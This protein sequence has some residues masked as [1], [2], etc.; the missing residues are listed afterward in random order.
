MTHLIMAVN[1]GSSSL[2]FE[3]FSM[4]EEITLA[5]GLFE[6]LGT[7]SA[8]F[9]LRAGAGKQ[10]ANVALD[11][12]QQA[13]EHLLDTLLQS[14]IVASLAQIDGV[15][16]RVAH[17]GEF[18]K[19]SA[20][21]DDAALDEIERLGALAPI[22]NPVNARGIRA[23]QRRLPH[24]VA[25]GVFDTSFHQTINEAGYLYPLPYRYYQDYGIRRYGFHGTS[26][27]YVAEACAGL[28]G[29]RD[30]R[31][32]SCHLGNG[33]SVCA[34]DGG[35]SVATSMGFTP[36]A[37]L[38]MG[39]RC[40]DIDPSILPFISEHDHKSAQQLL[41]IMNNA[42]GLLG[43]SGI[44]ND[45]RDIVSA[46][47]SGNHRAALALAM[48][49]DRIRAVI[50]AYATVMDGVDVVIFTAG[51]GENSAGIR[52]EVCRNLGFLGI[53][54]DDNKN[55][56]HATFIQQEGA[57][58]MV[59]VIPTNEELMIARDVMRVGLAPTQEVQHVG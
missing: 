23:F 6:R 59:T 34:I 14:G 17:G 51:I 5:K 22:H 38:M 27:K 31:I 11:N 52:R 18:F 43:V 7:G 1:S 53:R 8:A 41:E 56:R 49:T 45:C 37:G 32:I 15:G 3:L 16:H 42:S 54:L 4:P 39:T 29:R 30:L 9:T 12:H 36:L 25:V 57:P 48:F 55:K 2:K 50:G 26:H 24:A 58:V 46:A 35:R 21:I 40:G 28:L 13:A 10:Q 44:S 47:E 33:A 20:V 19:D